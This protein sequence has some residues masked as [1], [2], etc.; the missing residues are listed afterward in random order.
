MKVPP[1]IHLFEV[2][3][4]GLDLASEV[5]GGHTLHLKKGMFSKF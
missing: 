2:T 3:S 4:R 5:A 1:I